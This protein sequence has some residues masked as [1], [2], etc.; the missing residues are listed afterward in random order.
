MGSLRTDLAAESFRALGRDRYPG[1]AVNHWENMGVTVTEVIV[2][3]EEAAQRLG[4]PVGC[5]LS[6]ESEGLRMRDGDIRGILASMLGEELRRMILV[7]DN[8]GVMSGYT[9]VFHAAEADQIKAVLE[10]LVG[11][12][13]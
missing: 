2:Q 7:R 1:V 4:K 8:N 9:A 13:S 10:G 5:Y 12:A 6:L 3:S 11:L